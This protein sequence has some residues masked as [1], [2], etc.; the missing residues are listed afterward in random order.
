MNPS[1]SSKRTEWPDSSLG[2][3][4]DDK[5]RAELMEHGF[6]LAAAP[7][8]FVQTVRFSECLES[9][10]QGG[11]NPTR[12]SLE[13]LAKEVRAAITKAKGT[14][15]DHNEMVACDE[16]GFAW[17]CAKCGHIYGKEGCRTDSKRK[18]SETKTRDVELIEPGVV[19]VKCRKCGTL[20]RLEFGDL[21]GPRPR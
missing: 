13:S 20:I 14:P 2:S 8:L 11:F 16:R 3:I 4:R 10:L 21:T 5:T 9:I 6:M 17:K 7:D 12:K 15:C 18:P 1:T 19:R